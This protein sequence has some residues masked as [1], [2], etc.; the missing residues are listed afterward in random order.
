MGK[1]QAV[2]QQQQQRALLKRH[3]FSTTKSL[4]SD[5]A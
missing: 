5:F 3:A 4:P 2:K 1:Q